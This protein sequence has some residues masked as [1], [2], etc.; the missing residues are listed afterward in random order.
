MHHTTSAS[1]ILRRWGV[2]L[3]LITGA[4]LLTDAAGVGAPQSAGRTSAPV[5]DYRIVRIYP[6]D[7]HA[8]TQ[9][10]LYLD[11]ELYESTGLNGAS[12]I[13][14]VDLAS[15]SVLQRHDLDGKYFGE[16]LAAWGP[17]L[18]MLTLRSNLGFVYDRASL[19]PRQTFSYAGEGWGL[20]QD[21]TRLIMSDGT[22]V[23]R[24]LNPWTLSDAGSLPVRD[25]SAEVAG[26]NELE[27]VRGEIFANIWPTDRIARIAP[28]T[29][30]VTGWIDLAGLLP[31]GERPVS[32]SV[33]NGIAYDAQNDR[34]FVTGKRWPKLFEIRLVPRG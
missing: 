11:G 8:F 7:R 5:Y 14:R 30:F 31:P 6:H 27:Y 22:S 25:G 33:L 28:D 16:G 24:F 12:S 10:L 17:S 18:I 21:G 34:L 20:T 13:R 29:G 9:G 32:G 26:L 3:M 15:G 23:L 1:S 19:R 4:V 2:L